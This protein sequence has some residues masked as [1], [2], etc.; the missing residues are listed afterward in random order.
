MK[1]KDSIDIADLS[2]LD[3]FRIELENYTKLLE[4]GLVEVEQNPAP[5]KIEPLMRAAHSIKG[6]ARIVGLDPVSYTHLTL[7]TLYSV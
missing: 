2:M 1:D 5:E 6:A 7:P 4:V 3:L